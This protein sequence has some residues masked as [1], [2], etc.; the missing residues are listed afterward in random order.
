MLARELRFSD[1]VRFDPDEGKIDFC[2]R[3]A[4]LVQ[5]DAMGALRKELVDTLGL[6]I[7]K[8]ILSRYG[9]SCGHGDARDL[10]PHLAAQDDA[11]YVL[12]GP[13]LHGFE[14]VA[15]V[16]T[17]LLKVD[18]EGGHHEM[19]GTWGGSYE[20]EQHL[21]LF[22]LSAEP[23]CWTVAGYA[24]GFSSM[25]FNTP[26]ICIEDRCVARGDPECSWRLVPAAEAQDEREDY[27]RLFM[28][29]NLQ[30]QLNLLEQK[31]DY[32]PST[33]S[34]CAASVTVSVSSFFLACFL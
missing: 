10:G 15:Q 33:V 2:G 13:R 16:R 23:V 7:A 28:P 5:A 9:Y 20:A 1:F 27:R 3:R 14:G 24:S 6:D 25:V 29:L 31:E 18:K 32:V 8:V 26:M 21:R 34:R 17:T 4:V 12:A 19:S 30:A 22:G 11:E